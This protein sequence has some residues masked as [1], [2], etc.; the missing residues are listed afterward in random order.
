MGGEGKRSGGKGGEGKG[1][2]PLNRERAGLG[3]AKVRE[4]SENNRGMT[5]DRGPDLVAGGRRSGGGGG[6]RVQGS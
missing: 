4:N 5:G 6:A 2:P 3:P 1:I